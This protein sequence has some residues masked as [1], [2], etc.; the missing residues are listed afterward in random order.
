MFD[1]CY[2]ET[3]CGTMLHVLCFN[4]PI[5]IFMLV[6]KLTFRKITVLKCF[7]IAVVTKWFS[8]VL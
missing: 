1:F 6:L 2:N 5:Y 4:P 3:R 8:G 7:H